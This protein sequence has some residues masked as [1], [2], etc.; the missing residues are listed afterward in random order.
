MPQKLYDSALYQE[1]KQN[2]DELFAPIMTQYRW[3]FACACSGGADSLLLTLFMRQWLQDYSEFSHQLHALIIDH[4]WRAESLLE[5]QK[6]KQYLQ[7]YA[8]DAHILTMQNNIDK[9][10]PKKNSEAEA[11]QQRYQLLQ[12][13]CQQHDILFLFTGHQSDD[14]VEGFWL[15]LIRG[16]GL[17]G[18]TGLNLL[19]AADNVRLIRP[20]LSAD[21]TQIRDLLDSCAIPYIKDPAN[22]STKYKRN[23]IRQARNM[24]DEMGFTK[25]RILQTM[26]HLQATKQVMERQLT[27]L[28]AKHCLYHPLGFIRIDGALWIDWHDDGYQSLVSKILADAIARLGKGYAPRYQK[29]LAVKQILQNQPTLLCG[30]HI[31]GV[32]LYW[33]DNALYLF[34]VKMPDCKLFASEFFNCDNSH[35]HQHWQLRPLG[36]EGIK[37]WRATKASAETSWNAIKTYLPR[38]LIAQLPAW[39]DGEK[40]QAVPF[41]GRIS[42]LCVDKI[43][44][45]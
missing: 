16:S 45:L 37:Q 22:D 29:L 12:Q 39:F 30:R 1:F 24:F 34:P 3:H 8:I 11:R 14:K 19:R 43:K 40:L 28:K 25:Q 6:T 44:K 36:N 38:T 7:E 31:A 33:H 13:Y 27:M 17:Y 20:L 23:R 9:N 18:L 4:Q 26:Q 15:N 41:F 32:N 10:S 5:A 21:A 2:L 35:Q 42:P